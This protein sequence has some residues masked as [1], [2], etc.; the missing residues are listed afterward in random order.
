MLRLN[1]QIP[2]RHNLHAAVF[3]I[4]TANLSPLLSASDF[5]N[6]HTDTG[7]PGY[8]KRLQAASLCHQEPN[9][10]DANGHDLIRQAHHQ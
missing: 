6:T 9:G 4:W 1:V 8:R 3:Y 10:D 2:W 5:H 7:S